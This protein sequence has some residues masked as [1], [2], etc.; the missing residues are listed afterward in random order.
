MKPANCPYCG[1]EIEDDDE[2]NDHL[3]LMHP[4]KID[5]YENINLGGE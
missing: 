5:N 3:I 2:Y 1:E 4:D